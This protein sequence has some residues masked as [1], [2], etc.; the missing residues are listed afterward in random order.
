[1]KLTYIVPAELTLFLL[2]F[3]YT[4]TGYNDSTVSRKACSNK[5]GRIYEIFV[6]LMNSMISL[7][8]RG[9]RNIFYNVLNPL[10]HK[11]D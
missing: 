1:M 6:K 11:S 10:T 8:L 7:K 3:K 4:G 2:L 9:F 5:K